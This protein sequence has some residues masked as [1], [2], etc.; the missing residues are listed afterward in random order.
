MQLK[1]LLMTLCFTALAVGRMAS[2]HDVVSSFSK[3]TDLA[4]VVQKELHAVHNETST[5]ELW[6]NLDI[7]GLTNQIREIKSILE[8]VPGPI[9][10]EECTE[11][12]DAF[13]Q[14]QPVVTANLQVLIDKK[15]I[16]DSLAFGRATAIIGLTLSDLKH[17]NKGIQDVFL[18]LIP[19]GCKPE[20]LPL[21]EQVNAIY[22][23]SMSVY[24]P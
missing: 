5:L 1:P 14:M 21:M 7:N 11:I 19:D 4:A 17:L 2:T 13:Y 3:V 15:H 22:D 16:M 8:A 10:L 24:R 20:A 6:S 18:A 9:S 12:I 23:S